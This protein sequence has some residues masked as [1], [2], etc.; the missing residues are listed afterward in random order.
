MRLLLTIDDGLDHGHAHRLTIELVVT[1][2]GVVEYFLC[3]NGSI[4]HGHW[5][6]A[7]LWPLDDLEAVDDLACDAE[8]LQDSE[9]LAVRSRVLVDGVPHTR[10]KH[11]LQVGA[12]HPTRRD[13]IAVWLGAELRIERQRHLPLANQEVQWM[14]RIRY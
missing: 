4:R 13:V 6:F 7:H 9:Q 1:D 14:G 10:P 11:L 3:P 12:W 2:H 5:H 8:Q